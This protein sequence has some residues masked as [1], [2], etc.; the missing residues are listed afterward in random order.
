V[1]FRNPDIPSSV[2]Q[3]DPLRAAD[4]LGAGVRIRRVIVQITNDPVDHKIDHYLPWLSKGYISYLNGSRSEMIQ[5][6]DIAAHLNAGAFKRE[7]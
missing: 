4:T 1:T 2:V 5:A 3:V 7:N 6:R